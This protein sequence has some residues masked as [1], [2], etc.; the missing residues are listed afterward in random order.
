MNTYRVTLSLQTPSGSAWQADTL[1][2][3]LCWLCTWRYGKDVVENWK[4][5]FQTGNP[6]FVLSD[7]FPGDLLPRPYGLPELVT[8]QNKT[9]G[10]KQAIHQKDQKKIAWLTPREFNA[11]RRGE[12]VTVSLNEPHRAFT[13]RITFKNQINRDSNTTGEEGQLYPFVEQ[14]CQ[15]IS[16][17]VR[18]ADDEVERL[19]QLFEDLKQTGYGKRKSIG[20][21]QIEEY[22]FTLFD[23]PEID[24]PNGFVSL[25]HFVP[26]QHDPTDGQWKLN[27]KYGKLSG[28]R[29]AVEKPFKRPLIMLTPGSW[30]RTA[31]APKPWYGR[32]VSD[33]S[34]AF[35]DVVQYGLAFAVPMRLWKNKGL[36]GDED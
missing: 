5:R 32:L 22:R 11:L 9:E 27:V 33:V 25:S 1:F 29:A 28:E 23:F 17:Y 30:F 6:P 12:N 26:A 19:R 13:E 2:G 34:P 21:G 14:F 10:L 31:A 24:H 16:I 18:I 4:T 15:T 8:P 20:Y 3:H 7:G 35:P 36:E